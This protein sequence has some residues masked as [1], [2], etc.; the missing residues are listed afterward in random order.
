VG[1]VHSL[2]C[3]GTLREPCRRRFQVLEG[4]N[5]EIA[6]SAIAQLWWYGKKQVVDRV[7]AVG[8]RSDAWNVVENA[9]LVATDFGH[10]DG[11]ALVLRLL[12]SG[13]QRSRVA[14][15]YFAIRIGKIGGSMGVFKKLTPSRLHCS[16]H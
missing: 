5:P 14:G 8:L 11:G 3:H 16:G 12:A 15:A 10:A 7:V 6:D 4:P 2:G 13:E 1:I 9:A